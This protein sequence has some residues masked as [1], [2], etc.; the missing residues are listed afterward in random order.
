MSRRNLPNNLTQN[1]NAKLFLKTYNSL[2]INYDHRGIWVDFVTIFACSISNDLDKEQ[3]PRRNE[4]MDNAL[5]RYP[6]DDQKKIM[7][8]MDIT[9]AELFS[10]PNQDFF[11][12]IYNALDLYSK[13]KSQFFTPYNVSKMMALCLLGDPTEEISKKGMISINDSCC[14]GGALLIAAANVC[15]AQGV[16][17]SKDTLFVAQDIDPVVAMMC[18]IQLAL[19]GCAGYI[20]VG[21][22]L[23]CEPVSRDNTWLLPGLFNQ[24]WVDRGI[25]VISDDVKGEAV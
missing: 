5:K 23:S 3:R 7:E 13:A 22:S 24:V 17:I 18:Y 10:N 15:K 1:P 4:I 25:M 2:A 11:G 6:E 12:E 19:L 16:N 9:L 20:L 14:G 21:N 8:L